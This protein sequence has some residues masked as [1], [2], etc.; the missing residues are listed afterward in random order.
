MFNQIK[1]LLHLF[2]IGLLDE[3]GLSRGLAYA[4]ARGPRPPRA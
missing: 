3:A 1:R 2:D 4:A